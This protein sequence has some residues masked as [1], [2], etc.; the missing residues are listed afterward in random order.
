VFNHVL[1]F[2]EVAAPDA[3]HVGP[4]SLSFGTSIHSVTA[5]VTRIEVHDRVLVY[6]GDAGP[7]GD[8]Q[9][10]ASGA[11]L[12]LCEASMVGIRDADTYRFHL[13]AA[14]VGEMASW[15]G[16]GRLVLT[17]IPHTIDPEQ[18]IDQASAHFSGP[19][20]YAAPG[21]VFEI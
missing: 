7:G 13:T 3:A 17:H 12:L 4:L 18:A 2:R 6:S 14:E 16:V 1:D 15:A 21:S 10:M 20:S 8:L 5:N 9:E 19:V 11:D